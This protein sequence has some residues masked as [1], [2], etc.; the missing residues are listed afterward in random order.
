MIK[1]FGFQVLQPSRSR[2]SKRPPISELHEK[3]KK[4]YFIVLNC[5][6]YVYENIAVHELLNDILRYLNQLIAAL[7]NFSFLIPHA[8]VP[9]SN[10]VSLL[11]MR[12]FSCVSYLCLIRLNLLLNNMIIMVVIVIVDLA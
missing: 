8:P 5:Y 1:Y 12:M 10:S 2:G 6:A 4:H 9:L 11:W 7:S 3:K